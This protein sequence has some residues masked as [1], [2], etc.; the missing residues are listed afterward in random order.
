M[1]IFD[2]YEPNGSPIITPSSFYQKLEKIAD[3]AVVC[4]S[5]DARD[6]VLGKHEHRLYVS[7][8]ATA[9]GKMDLYYLPEFGVLFFMSPIGASVAG[10]MLEEVAYF[11][12]VTKF[13]YFGSCGILDPQLKGKFIAPTSCY[14]EEGYSYHYAAPS[15]YIDI[16]NH[17]KVHDFIT[18]LGLDCV[19]GK[20][21]TTDAIYNE[22]RAKA[23]RL[24]KEGVICVDMEASGLQAIANHLGL[25][26]Y[27]FFFSGDILSNEWTRG[28]LGGQEE[29]VRQKD[30]SDVALELGKSLC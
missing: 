1:S 25:E 27:I 5:C 18:S 10:G 20:G 3:V 24:R 17:V 23:D 12:G 4:F 6:H 16:K 22:T 29:E 28:D 30:S 15:E 26:V 19:S 21:W 14:R 7:V 13:V 8:R 11:S 9:N 2:A